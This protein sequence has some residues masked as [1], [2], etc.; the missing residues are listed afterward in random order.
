VDKQKLVQELH[1]AK[2]DLFNEAITAGKIPLRDGVIQ[3]V[4]EAIAAGVPLAVCSTSS[5]R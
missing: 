4:D 5:D 3:L 1:L 2:T